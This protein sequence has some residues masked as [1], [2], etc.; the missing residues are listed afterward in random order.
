[1]TGVKGK[2]LFDINHSL[3]SMYCDLDLL[4]LKF[5]GHILHSWGVLIWIFMMVGVKGK[6]LC[7]IKAIFGYQCIVT[8]TL[9]LLTLKFMGLILDL[10][11]V[12][13]W[14]FMMTDIKGKQLCDINHFYLSMHCDLWH[15]DPEIHRAYPWLMGSLCAKF[16][17]QCIVTLTFDI[18]IR[19][20]LDHEP[21]GVLCSTLGQI[22]D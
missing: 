17:Y 12:F 8:L 20:P 13:V 1:M 15:F 9:D 4:T 19:K 5:I 16:S 7:D 22:S 10:W 18:L 21:G 2:Q 3:L 11:R 14:S 6:Q